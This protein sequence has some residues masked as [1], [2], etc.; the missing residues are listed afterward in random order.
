M[1]FGYTD[2]DMIAELD[3]PKNDPRDVVRQVLDALEA[4]RPKCSPTT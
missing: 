3:V 2:T 1:H 4:G